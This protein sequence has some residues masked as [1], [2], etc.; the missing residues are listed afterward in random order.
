MQENTAAVEKQRALVIGDDDRLARAIALI[1]DSCLDV[2]MIELEPKLSQPWECP[3]GDTDLDLIVLALSSAHSKP[4]VILAR[5]S[6]GERIG[7]VPIL[8]IS[9]RAFPF[10]SGENVFHMDFFN[11]HKLCAR[12]QEI[13]DKHSKKPELEGARNQETKSC[14]SVAAADCPIEIIHVK[15]S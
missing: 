7:Q 9:E 5:A 1:L 4:I 12:A 2:N 14:V 11:P 13:L 3:E 6:L 15:E 8:I 10:Y